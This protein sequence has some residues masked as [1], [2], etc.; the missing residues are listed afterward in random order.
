MERRIKEE[1]KAL[2]DQGRLLD[3]YMTRL[4]RLIREQNQNLII[5]Q[6]AT[7]VQ[8]KETHGRKTTHYSIV[9]FNTNKK[10]ESFIGDRVYT[11]NCTGKYK[12]LR[13]A[14]VI[15]PLPRNKVKLQFDRVSQP[16]LRLISNLQ[17][18]EP[19]DR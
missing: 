19:R 7:S 18:T 12:G 4:R 9:G 10:R 8:R 2:K 1:K 17:N 11:N 3:R 14:T 15:S 16:T 13:E 5:D 6:A